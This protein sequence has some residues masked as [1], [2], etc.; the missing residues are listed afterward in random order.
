ML[1][2]VEGQRT[3]NKEL[4]LI[5]AIPAFAP[6]AL[7]QNRTTEQ[8]SNDLCCYSLPAE[9]KRYNI[10]TAQPSVLC[11]ISSEINNRR[12]EPSG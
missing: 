6:S 9:T 11:V 1:L 2:G 7:F 10:S 12:K 3:G 8:N 4:V 5:Q